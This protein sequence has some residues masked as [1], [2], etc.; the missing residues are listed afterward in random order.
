MSESAVVARRSQRSEARHESILQAAAKLFAERGFAKTPVEEIAMAAGVSK[1]LVYVYFDSKEELLE[2]VLER[3]VVEWT[4]ATLRRASE[5]S[6][7]ME[8]IV[9][10]LRASVAHVSEDPILRGILAQDLS[11]AVLPD[12]RRKRGKLIAQYITTTQMALEAASARGEIREDL[13]FAQ[14]AELIWMIHD[15]IVRASWAASRGKDCPATPDLVE[16]A[17]ELIQVGLARRA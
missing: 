2:L 11:E 1:G 3:A 7:P 12:Q 16:T 13:D 17:V 10:G 15:G 14:L 5:I 4:A 6:S 9:S 8:L